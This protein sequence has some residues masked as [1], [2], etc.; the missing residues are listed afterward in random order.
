V[1]SGAPRFGEQ[2]GPNT[3]LAILLQPGVDGAGGVW[4]DG[5][6][7]AATLNARAPGQLLVQRLGDLRALCATTP[8]ALA[9]NAVQP[10]NAEALPGDFAEAYPAAYWE[11]LG[12]FLARLS[13][14]APGVDSADTL[15]YAPAEERFWHFPTDERLQTAASGLFVAGDATVQSQGV[16][17]AGVAGMLAGEGVARYLTTG[18]N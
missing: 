11:A 1:A 10:S 9:A 5:E 4:A 6:N 8:S 18:L 15:V 16:I 14:L 7:A 17:Q 2:R 3:T 13:Q 12:D